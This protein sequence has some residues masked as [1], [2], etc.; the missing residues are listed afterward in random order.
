MSARKTWPDTHNATSL[1]ALEDG[2][3]HCAW[4]AGQTL[5]LFGPAP[6]LANLSA[7]QAK[8]RGLLTSGTYGRPSSTSSSSAALQ[9]SLESRL[10]ALMGSCG[11]TLYELTWKQ[12]ATPQGLPICALRAS[13]RRTSGS[14]S[15]GWPTPCTQDGPKGGPGQGVDR[16]PG[17]VALTGWPT[18]QARDFK[19]A[20]DP[21]NKLT[22]NARPLNEIAK[23]AGRP[24]PLRQDGDSS[25]GEGAIARGTR[26][27][28]GHTLTSIT[29]HMQPVRL[30]ASGEMLT[31]FLA[32]M[33]SGGQLNPAH[34]RWLMGYPPEWDVCGVTAMPSCRKSRRRS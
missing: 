14:A 6:A 34:S 32:G 3:S 24:T 8:A 16:L 20:N 4:R 10:R 18:R 33:E 28:R 29:M 17:A 11:S 23:L 26:G 19:G 22:H 31:G 2:A 12:R 1:L 27:T 25:G 15:T 21:G 7:R 30:T 5:D 9:S 13:A